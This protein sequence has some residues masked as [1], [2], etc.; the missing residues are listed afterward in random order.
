MIKNCYCKSLWALAF[1]LLSNVLIAQNSKWEINIGYEHLANIPS[2]TNELSENNWIWN[3]EGNEYFTM[4]TSL[5]HSP[6]VGIKYDVT[7]WLSLTYNYKVYYRRYFVW[8]GTYLHKEWEGNPPGKFKIVPFVGGLGLP[9]MFQ[10]R[11]LTVKSNQWGLDFHHF[12]STNRRWKMH[13]LINLNIDQYENQRSFRDTPVDYGIS[14]GRFESI[15]GSTT[16]WEEAG[17]FTIT[18]NSAGR[19]STLPSTN[20]AIGFSKRN[21][22]GRG[23]RFE[24]G[25]RDIRRTWKLPKNEWDLSLVYTEF[26]NDDS[27]NKIVTK[28]LETKHSFPLYLGGIYA[29]VQYTFRPFRSRF[30]DPDYKRKKLHLIPKFIRKK[31]IKK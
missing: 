6:V 28:Q 4:K 7:K 5:V 18:T 14:G 27:G 9:D 20:F 29:N 15:D 16:Y 31:K 1:I 22:I 25:F 11:T 23:V 8:S 24:I 19:K 17:D 10:G 2:L 30:D 26:K 13:Y 21:K 3:N 12:L